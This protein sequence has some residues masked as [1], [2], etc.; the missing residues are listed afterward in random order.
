MPYTNF[1]A[2]CSGNP[3]ISSKTTKLFKENID[4]KSFLSD[5]TQKAVNL[6]TK[7]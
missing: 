1:I 4:E 5:N 7:L 2:K 3:N 6:K